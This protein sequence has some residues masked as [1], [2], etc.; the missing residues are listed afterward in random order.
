MQ[1]IKKNIDVRMKMGM[2]MCV[3]WQGAWQKSGYSSPKQ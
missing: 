3:T 2:C 1:H